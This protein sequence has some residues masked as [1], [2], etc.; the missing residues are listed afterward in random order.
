MS[1]RSAEFGEQCSDSYDVWKLHTHPAAQ[2]ITN[3]ERTSTC[4]ILRMSIDLKYQMPCCTTDF[5]ACA[6]LPF[7]ARCGMRLFLIGVP[8]SSSSSSVGKRRRRFGV[9]SCESRPEDLG[10][11]L[12]EC[13]TTSAHILVQP[14][15]ECEHN[16]YLLCLSA[17][18]FNTPNIFLQDMCYFK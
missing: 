17:Q 13:I 7:K 14:Q 11:T 6:L 18:A 1:P 5:A 15:Y 3:N 12:R 10:L 8:S 9:N 2:H 4:G 16:K